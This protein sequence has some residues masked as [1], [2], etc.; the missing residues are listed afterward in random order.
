MPAAAGSPGRRGQAARALEGQGYD[1]GPLGA[2]GRRHGGRIPD[3]PVWLPGR[4]DRS[5]HEPHGARR[6][7]Q[8]ACFRHRG[9]PRVR[10]AAPEDRKV[11]RLHVGR[12]RLPDR[13]ARGDDP[14]RGALRRLSRGA[15]DPHREACR[16]KGHRSSVHGNTREV[17]ADAQP[18]RLL[19]RA[20][21][22]ELPQRDPG[23]RAHDLWRR[24]DLGHLR[25]LRHRRI[26]PDQV[27][28]RRHQSNDRVARVDRRRIR[29]HEPRRD[30]PALGAP[31]RPGQLPPLPAGLRPKAPGHPGDAAGR[32][33]ADHHFRSRLRSHDAVERPLA[34]ARD[35]ARVCGRAQR[36]GA[37]P[38]GR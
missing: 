17:R 9:D 26:V 13:G 35:V 34:R 28:R 21:A 7:L 5:V 3:L 30:R 6:A 2:D 23:R 31:Q 32:R 15:R 38:R 25:R 22:P 16:R 4:R 36:C 1:R 18:P 27:E 29:V 10:R 8:Q 20:A 11:D 19:A 33:P 37:H 24:E 14:A 12:F